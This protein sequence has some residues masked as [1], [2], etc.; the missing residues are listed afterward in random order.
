MSG[1]LFRRKANSIADQSLSANYDASN[2]AQLRFR[3]GERQ[4]LTFK[5][6]WKSRSC[7]YGFG[8][9]F[10]LGAGDSGGAAGAL[11]AAVAAGGGAVA[12]GIALPAGTTPAPES[13]AAEDTGDG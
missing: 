13:G 6:A 4:N 10:R 8:V 3:E 12:G 5:S 11:A 7:N 1:S 2:K 9:A